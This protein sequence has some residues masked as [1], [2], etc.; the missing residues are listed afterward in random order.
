MRKG[1]SSSGIE[2]MEQSS[3]ELKNFQLRKFSFQII[4]FRNSFSGTFFEEGWVIER[5]NVAGS[6]CLNQEDLCLNILFRDLPFKNI[7]L[8]MLGLRKF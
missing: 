5:R 6:E 8:K 3:T 1:T 7:V 4:G 2:L